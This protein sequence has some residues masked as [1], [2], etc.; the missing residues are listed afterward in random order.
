MDGF[1]HAMRRAVC[2]LVHLR[3]IARDAAGAQWVWVK[4]MIRDYG[5]EGEAWGVRARVESRVGWDKTLNE[6][7]N[8]AADQAPV[9]GRNQGNGSVAMCISSLHIAKKN[10]RA[11]SC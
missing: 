7:W 5:R 9:K 4:I 8:S 11:N 3:G 6:R 2:L 10:R 1:S